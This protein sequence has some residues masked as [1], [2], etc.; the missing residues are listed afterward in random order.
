MDTHNEA[1]KDYY[2]LPAL[3]FSHGQLRLSEDN[4][5][6]LDGFRTDT[7]DYLLNLSINLSLDKAVENGAWGSSAYSH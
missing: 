5:G 4:A 3:E 7:L 2:I 6:F 1:I